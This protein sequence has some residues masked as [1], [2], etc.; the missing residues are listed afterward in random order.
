MITDILLGLTCIS[1]LFLGNHFLKGRK[2]LKI[3]IPSLIHSGNSMLE[4]MKLLSKNSEGTE[5]QTL[6][7]CSR[8]LEA[9]LNELSSIRDRVFGKN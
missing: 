9:N 5:K 6:E 2:E 8:E 7:N 3:I 1:F 4:G